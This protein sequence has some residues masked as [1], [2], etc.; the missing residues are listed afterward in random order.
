V[1]A[2]KLL[3][4]Y[5]AGLL[6]DILDHKSA[7]LRGKGDP[8]PQN[9]LEKLARFRAVVQ[10]QKRNPHRIADLAVSGDDLIAIGFS[11]GPKIGEAL[12]ALLDEV[13]RS[14]ELNTREELLARAAAM[15]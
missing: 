11:P 15:R 4:R 10:K 2:R 12:R 5:G 13:V 1:R 14:P 8:P 7:D 6:F 9:D 3:A